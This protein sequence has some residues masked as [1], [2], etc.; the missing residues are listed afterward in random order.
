MPPAAAPAKGGSVYHG[1]PA[2][3]EKPTELKK[4]P[5]SPSPDTKGGEE[6]KGKSLGG[7]PVIPEITPAASRT[8]SGS[9]SPF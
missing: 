9:K 6:P 2:A 1:A 7:I 8:E 5:G 3:G 4:L